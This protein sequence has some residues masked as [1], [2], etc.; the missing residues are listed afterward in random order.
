MTASAQHSAKSARIAPTLTS[1]IREPVTR[2]RRFRDTFRGVRDGLVTCR[3]RPGSP[4]AAARIRPSDRSVSPLQVHE[5]CDN[6]CHRYISCLKGKMPIDLVID[7]RDSGGAAAKPAEHGHGDTNNNSGNSRAS[8]EA[9]QD[10][11]STPDIV[12]TRGRAAP[13]PAP[14]PAPHPRPALHR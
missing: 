4:R 5:L 6:F 13:C 12:S 10:G 7:E 14:R 2:P 8:A 3:D 1:S 11:T 9:S